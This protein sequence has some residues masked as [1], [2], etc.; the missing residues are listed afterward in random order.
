MS[1]LL[2]GDQARHGRQ[3]MCISKQ[4]DGRWLL[5]AIQTKTGMSRPIRSGADSVCIMDID[6]RY[7]NERR[8]EVKPYRYDVFESVAQDL[9]NSEWTFIGHCIDLPGVLAATHDRCPRYLFRVFSDQ[10]M[11]LNTA[12]GFHS[13][14]LQESKVYVAISS[15]T[16][17]SLSDNLR[18]INAA[19]KDFS[20][21]WV[22]FTMSLQFALQ[23]ALKMKSQG[24]TNICISI[25]DTINLS[26]PIQIFAA[27]ALT[28][29]FDVHSNMKL[30]NVEA[31]EFLAWEKV[32]A[33]GTVIALERF[34]NIYELKDG[35]LQQGYPGVNPA[36]IIP[37]HRQPTLKGLGKH[38]ITKSV[39]P[40]LLRKK[41]PND[42]KRE[43]QRQ[44]RAE[45]SPKTEFRVYGAGRKFWGRKINDPLSCDN[46]V[47]IDEDVLHKIFK[48]VKETFPVDKQFDMLIQILS[49]RPR[50]F[51]QSSI[52]EKLP[53]V[54]DSE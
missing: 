23:F 52:V 35:Q 15:M 14:A 39:P 53:A 5:A 42:A 48:L 16:E 9:Y 24:N 25:I 40:W 2:S 22:S 4:E 10:S 21:H 1:D 19:K 32:E 45:Q 51:E 49:S 30:K 28:R 12:E 29:A 31:A 37:S 43:H 6:R 11:G 41:Y 47:P 36:V 17:E 27:P 3:E 46:R 7:S 33:P 54:M 34:L 13:G 38:R 44:V 50:F 20:S 18:H 26:S 8:H